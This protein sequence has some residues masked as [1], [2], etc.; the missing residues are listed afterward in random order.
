MSEHKL[1]DIAASLR[2]DYRTIDL[3]HAF[4][5]GQPTFSGFPDEEREQ[6]YSI[7]KDGFNVDRYSIVGQWGT[8]I[9]A[10]GHFAA[11]ERLLDAIGPEEFI[12]PLVVLDASEDAAQNPDFVAGVDLIERHEEKY[13]Q[14]PPRSFV[15]LRTDW[16][17]RWESGDMYNPDLEGTFHS[18]GWGVPALEF[19]VERRAVTAIG[20]ETTDTDPGRSVQ[21]G[22][23]P[24]ETY[25]LSTGR[26]QIELLTRLAEVPATG[27]L[28]RATAP[29]PKDGYGFPARAYAVAPREE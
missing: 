5:S 27:A 2:D 20:H 19:L 15:A 24:A 17:K 28:I 4:H 14:I 26:W 21:A 6:L 3:T 13:G 29:K 11:G 9:D 16:S 25:I 22:K 23:L 8:H 7:E 18:P 1:W 12:L 10:P